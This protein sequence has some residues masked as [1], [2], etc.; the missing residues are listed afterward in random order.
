MNGSNTFTSLYT[1]GQAMLH[2]AESIVFY[3]GY[4]AETGQT[5]LYR[6]RFSAEPGGALQVGPPEALVE[7][8]ENMQLLYGQDRELTAV[9]PS[10]YIDS[11]GTATDVEASLTDTAQGWRRVGAVQVGL[12][13]SSSSPPAA[14][15]AE[16]DAAA[17]SALGVAFTAPN[18]GRMRAVYQ[19]TV[20]LRNRLY[21]N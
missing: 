17:L 4:D 7:G 9:S 13:M 8:V 3:V 1:T 21:G 16:G 20:A 15:Q 19:T 2:R 14:K 6:L 18:D 5:S 11:Q 10:G 12:V